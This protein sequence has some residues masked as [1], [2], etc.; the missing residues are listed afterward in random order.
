MAVIQAVWATTSRAAGRS[1]ARAS[2]R[3]TRPRRW[4]SPSRRA[5]HRRSISFKERDSW[6]ARS[7]PRSRTTCPT[8]SAA[9]G[10]PGWPCTTPGCA[11]AGGG[12]PHG[13]AAH[14][15]PNPPRPGRHGGRARHAGQRAPVARPDARGTASRRAPIPHGDAL[16][17]ALI[18]TG[19]HD[20][21]FLTDEQLAASPLRLPVGRLH[22]V[23]RGAAGSLRAA[24]ERAGAA[25]GDR[26]RD[27]DDFVMAGLE[28]GDVVS[29]SS[30]RAATATSRRDLPRPRATADAP[31][32]GLLLVDRRADG[33][34]DAI[35]HVGKHGTLE[36]LPGKALGLSADAARCAARRHAADLPVHRQRPRRGRPGQAAR[37]CGDR[38]SPDAADDEGRHLRRDGGARETSRRVRAS[39]RCSTHQAAVSSRCASGA[40]S[41]TQTCRPTSASRSG[42]TTSATLV[43][44]IDGYLCEVKDIQIKDGLH[45]LGTAATRRSDARARV[46]HPA[47][48]LG[49]RPPACAAPW[50]PPSGSTSRR[51]SPPPALPAPGAMPPSCWPASV[52]RRR[53]RAI[54]WI[55]WKPRRWRC[56]TR[57]PRRT[58]RA[59]SVSARSCL[60]VLGRRRRR[61]VE[62]ALSLRRRR[63]RPAHPAGRQTSSATCSRR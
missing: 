61:G 34:R 19:G 60:D 21:E 22:R 24:I 27:G 33:A 56:W 50:A 1:R 8:R 44:H 39:S 15:L 37:A 58:W 45:I 7:A 47:P 57:W 63:G 49:R 38:R 42:P 26:Y 48:R 16:M 53:A 40:R 6:L 55:A 59:D 2:R 32:C 5:D 30:R 35:V 18:A 46:R 43:E 4:R 9:P 17:H 29:R 12:A 20:P 41:S 10:W 11:R 52:A 28:L 14:A 51:S 23:V 54:S 36:W 25:A 31:L 13:S 3:S 62:R